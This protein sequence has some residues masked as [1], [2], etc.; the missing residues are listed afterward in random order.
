M[1]LDKLLLKGIGTLLV[2]YGYSGVGKSF[3]LF[4]NKDNSGLLQA[5]INN[6]QQSGKIN[7]IKIRVYEL[8]GMGLAYPDLWNDY[9][10]VDQRIIDYNLILRKD[11]ENIQTIAIDN[12]NVNY[13]KDIK[14]YVEDI[15]DGNNF[16]SLPMEKEQLNKTLS[17]FNSFVKNIET[18]RKTRT[19][20]P[21]RIRSTVNNPDSSRSKLIYD[22]IIEFENRVKT[23]FVIDDTPGAEN[24]ISTYIENNNKLSYCNEK[25]PKMDKDNKPVIKNNKPQYV[26]K[27]SCNDNIEKWQEAMLYAI[28]I[29]PLYLAVLAPSAVVM[30]CDILMLQNNS[31]KTILQKYIKDI[32]YTYNNNYTNDRYLNILMNNNNELNIASTTEINYKIATIK[33]L[34]KS[35]SLN[36]IPENYSNNLGEQQLK[37]SRL[38]VNVDQN[39]ALNIIK[40]II[41][42]C[43]TQDVDPSKSK[44]ELLLDFLTI[45]LLHMNI[46]DR[47]TNKNLIQEKKRRD[48]LK[49]YYIK[50]FNTYIEK[51][52]LYISKRGSDDAK[53]VNI[54]F[55]LNNEN[56]IKINNTFVFN[57][58]FYTGDNKIIWTDYNSIN[59]HVKYFKDDYKQLWLDINAIIYYSQPKNNL[60]YN[61]DRFNEI[62]D[63]ITLSMEANFIN[64]N[65]LG[66]MKETAIKSGVPKNTARGTIGLDTIFALPKENMTFKNQIDIV[67]NIINKGIIENNK[68]IEQIKNNY[69]MNIIYDMKKENNDTTIVKEIIDPYITGDKPIIEDYKM[70]YVLQNNDTQL[71]CLEQFKLYHNMHPF[72]NSLDF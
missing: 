20:L 21:I 49:N 14:T 42:Y 18:N 63:F 15:K 27:V 23:T 54:V 26:K 16:L 24:P 62:K 39:K 48:K 51:H 67:N 30:A 61:S 8:Y 19:T 29:N 58:H 56:K 59:K 4:G 36:I 5:T 44:Y 25:I 13:P 3:T 65:I 37:V 41:N 28:L 38:N 9:N 64:Q 11:E 71:K 10:K 43:H 6:L 34:Q 1:L 53:K 69:N 57:T 70:F 45:I 2:T 17:K 35:K 68:I 12:K 52:H 22:F 47:Q 46:Y 50:L 7:N 72:L 60:K 32:Q 31:Y 66:I 40:E 33:I 55:N